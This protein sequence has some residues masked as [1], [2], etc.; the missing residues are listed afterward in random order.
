MYQEILRK[1]LPADC[2]VFFDMEATEIR[3]QAIS[4]GMVGLKKKSG[5]SLGELEEA[6]SYHTYLKTED[7]IGE[8]VEN[9]TGITPELIEKEGKTFSEA[10]VEIL[11]ILRPFSKKVYLSYSDSDMMILAHTIHKKIN[12]EDNFFRM[13][14]NSY[15]D[16]QNY[17]SKRILSE[18]GKTLSL[19]KLASLLQVEEE[20]RKHDALS[21]SILL[22]N[23]FLQYF[24]REDLVYPLA[25]R[26]LQTS[27]IGKEIKSYLLEEV[28]AGREVS[29]S[30]F[31]QKV[32]TLL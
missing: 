6:F 24:K 5:K 23:V 15:L 32:R 2:L 12:V 11:N 21:D 17:Y 19:F 26:S 18:K 1:L 29:L 8:F 9:L 14:S 3:H 30:S 13:I 10:L 16:L 25:I 31:E 4:F 20:D 27:V 28:L 22:K 7:N